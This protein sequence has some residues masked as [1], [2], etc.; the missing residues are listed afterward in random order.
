MWISF[1]N[2]PISMVSQS[3]WL[4]ADQ[5]WQAFIEKHQYYHDHLNSAV[6][7]PESKDYDA[8]VKSDMMLKYERWDGKGSTRFLRGNSGL[9]V[10]MDAEM[11]P[12]EFQDFK[13]AVRKLCP[14]N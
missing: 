7:D 3:E 1:Q 5:Y 8:K 11:M 10:S 2:P 13:E 14:S 12:D 9:L 4:D 6:E